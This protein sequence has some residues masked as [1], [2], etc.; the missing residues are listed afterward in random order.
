MTSANGTTIGSILQDWV[1]TLGLRHQGVLLTA[2]RGCDTVPRED[3]SKALTRAY[4]GTILNAHCG[5]AAKAQTFIEAVGSDDLRRRMNAVIRDHDALPHHYIMHLVHAAEIVG[6]KH[7][8]PDVRRDWLAFY[9]G[10][11]GKFHM[12]VEAEAELDARLDADE[13]TFGRRNRA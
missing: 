2:V 7:P 8:D 6:Y 1:A 13:D 11:V 4:R 12:A 10:M 5:D 9:A 3:P